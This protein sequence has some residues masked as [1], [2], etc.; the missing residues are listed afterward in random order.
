MNIS[1]NTMPVLCAGKVGHVS[2][3]GTVNHAVG[4]DDPTAGLALHDDTLDQSRIQGEGG[5]LG[6]L[7]SPLPPPLQKNIEKGKKRLNKRKKL[8]FLTYKLYISM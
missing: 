7:T 4:Q 8:A 3:A 6:H 5:A 1:I 2:V